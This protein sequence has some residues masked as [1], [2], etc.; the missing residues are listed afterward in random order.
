MKKLLL[1]FLAMMLVVGIVGIVMAVDPASQTISTNGTATISFSVNSINFGPV[2]PHQV[3]QRTSNITLD[4][5]NNIDFDVSI[6]LQTPDF[7]FDEILFDLIGYGGESDERLGDLDLSAHID[8][9][10]TTEPGIVQVKQIPVSLTV[11][12]GILPGPRNGVIVYTI[13][14]PIF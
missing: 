5:E 11:P 2:A 4:L 7:V 8:D 13:T 14:S 10:D 12:A 9:T 6:Q 3:V 1:V